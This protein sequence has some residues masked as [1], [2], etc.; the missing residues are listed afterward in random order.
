MTGGSLAPGLALNTSTGVVSGV[1]TTAGSYSATITLTVDGYKE[2]G[3]AVHALTVEDL[4][5]HP[6]SLS[7]AAGSNFLLSA[8][9]L[10]GGGLTVESD[11]AN[12]VT[13][14]YSMVP[15]PGGSDLPVG[16]AH[17]P[18]ACTDDGGVALNGQR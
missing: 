8:G 2:S 5:L 1:P 15:V 3:S 11:P 13:L 10:Y 7:F 6:E 12:G 17:P 16:D 18:V 4:T 14:N 9:P